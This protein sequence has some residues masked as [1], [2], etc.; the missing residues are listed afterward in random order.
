MTSAKHYNTYGDY[1]NGTYT[2]TGE[3]SVGYGYDALGNM[4]S[5]T[6][7]NVTGEQAV[8]QVYDGQNLALVLN[9]SGEVV[10]RVLNGPAVDQVLAVEAVSPSAGSEAAGVVNWYLADNQGTVRDVVILN[11][12]FQTQNVDHLVYEP[13]GAIFSQTTPGNQ[14][15]TTFDGMWQDPGTDLSR[16]RPAGTTPPTADGWAGTRSAS[17]A[18]RRI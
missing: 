15:I 2:G 9:S 18:A 12:S 1:Q 17:A 4:V 8:Y 16:A 7:Q 3:Y 13:F 6:P 11:T 10:E 14:P 5:R